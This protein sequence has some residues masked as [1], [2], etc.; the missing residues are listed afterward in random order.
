MY[1][2]K[3]FAIRDKKR[4]ANKYVCMGKFQITILLISVAVLLVSVAQKLRLPYPIVL[5]FGGALIGFLPEMHFIQF[6]P[7]LVLSIILPPILY[8]TAFWTPLR[9]FVK[10]SLII[11]SLAIGLVTVTCCFV[12]WVF[13]W[14]FPELPLALAFAFG[15]I[16]SPPDA[17]SA[18]AIL[19]RFPISG[20]LLT[21]LEGESLINDACAIV[22]YKVALSALLTGVFSVQSVCVSVSWDVFG[23]VVLGACFGYL[24][25]QFARF[26][27]E[28]VIGVVFSLV[29][30]YITYIGAD[31][32]GVSG[33]LATVATGL[34][35]MPV[36]VNHESA[37][38]RMLGVTI[39]DV[40]IIL[41]NCFV[42]IL[43]GTEL[44]FVTAR[45][46]VEDLAVYSGYGVFITFVMIAVR[47]GWV[48]F[49]TLF[50]YQFSKKRVKTLEEKTAL[51]ASFFSEAT[52]ISWSGMRGIVSLSCAL[53]LPYYQSDGSILLGREITVFLTFIVTLLSLI[54]PGFTLSFLM[55]FLVPSSSKNQDKEPL[56]QKL[57]SVV[58][59]VLFSLE[60][61]KKLK[62]EHASFLKEYFNA[63]HSVLAISTCEEDQ[64]QPVEEARLQV[65]HA[66]RALIVK[67][68]KEKAISQHALWQFSRELDLEEALTAR[69]EIE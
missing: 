18:T 55:R 26:Y 16:I 23:G 39:W 33:V 34:V 2:N 51:R 19:K 46:S 31:F 42:F 17:A 54:I 40:F 53:A 14:L 62:S 60:K 9:E 4:S 36:I 63:R 15:A 25:Q 24:V 49:M 35:S 45:M 11:L 48:F 32:L 29:I 22:L 50:E 44:R 30:P 47:M 13:Y 10:H 8:Y 6:D 67:L 28:P 37:L 12:A 65:L 69:A 57:I 5:V 68:W 27:L 52:I 20:K 21:V 3:R 61:E 56:R 64:F 66:Q 38:R 41:L 7:E 1:A 59:S 58:D 43:I